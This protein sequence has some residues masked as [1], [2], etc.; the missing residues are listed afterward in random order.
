MQHVKI[1]LMVIVVIVHRMIHVIERKLKIQLVQYRIIPI[2]VYMEHVM[3]ENVL[4]F[5]DGLEIFVRKMLM[6]V[7]WIHVLIK[8]LVM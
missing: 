4:V 1:Y 6:N 5:L 8:E 7:K 2:N 3:M